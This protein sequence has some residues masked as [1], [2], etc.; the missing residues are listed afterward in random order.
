MGKQLVEKR[1]ASWVQAF[2][3]AVKALNERP[4]E[5]LYGTAPKNVD[6]NDELSYTLDYNAGREVRA[7][8]LLMHRLED[9][10][11]A[12]G[13]FR[14]QLPR[15]QW[16]K[17][18]QPRYSATVYQVKSI[19]NEVVEDTRG[20]F[21]RLFLAQPVTEGESTPFP[22]SVRAGN[23][24]QS[25]RRRLA[26]QPYMEALKAALGEGSMSL[27]E[28]GSYLETIPGYTAALRAQNLDGLRAVLLLFDAFE[29]VGAGAGTR[30][31]VRAD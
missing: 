9:R 22:L 14:V 10:L 5:H 15:D 2:T 31:S 6:G 26:M 30:V 11:R 20:G 3:D 12:A 28:A 27:S 17:A 8:S 21:H 24:Q 19:R 7:Q 4:S 13:K 16:Q 18:Y 1:E 23:A 29:L 25:E